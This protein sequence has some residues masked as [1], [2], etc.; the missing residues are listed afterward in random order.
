MATVSVVSLQLCGEATVVVQDSSVGD[1][2]SNTVTVCPAALLPVFAS[3]LE[4]VVGAG[5]GPNTSELAAVAKGR[6]PTPTTH[7]LPCATFA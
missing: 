7:A 1:A 3:R 6:A 2:S 4:I 5:S